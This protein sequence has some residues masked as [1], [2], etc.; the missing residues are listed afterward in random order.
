MCS[1]VMAFFFWQQGEQPLLCSSVSQ[2]LTEIRSPEKAHNGL[3]AAGRFALARW[4]R[5]PGIGGAEAATLLPPRL[6]KGRHES[7]TRQRFEL[8]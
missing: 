8:R 2:P 6:A 1:D 4:H 3:L 7:K 5:G